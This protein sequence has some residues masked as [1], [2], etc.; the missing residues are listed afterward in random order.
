[1]K[2]LPRLG[3]VAGIVVVFRHLVPGD[4]GLRFQ[5]LKLVERGNP[6][7]PALRIGLAKIGMVPRAGV[8]EGAPAFTAI[9]SMRQPIRSARGVRRWIRSWPR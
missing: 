4:H 7:K 8:G 5:S 9:G 2:V 1:V 3:N 6:L